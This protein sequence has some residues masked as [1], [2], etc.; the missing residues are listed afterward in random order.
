MLDLQVL[1][2]F[3]LSALQYKWLTRQSDDETAL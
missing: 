3:M 1:L 2:M